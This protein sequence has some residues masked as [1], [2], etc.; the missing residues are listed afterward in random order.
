MSNRKAPCDIEEPPSFDSLEAVAKASNVDLSM[1]VGKAIGMEIVKNVGPDGLVRKCAITNRSVEV[2]PFKQLAVAANESAEHSWEYVQMVAKDLHNQP[3]PFWDKFDKILGHHIKKAARANNKAKEPI[4]GALS[5]L[6]S[7]PLLGSVIQT[8]NRS[9]FGGNGA[10]MTV[11]ITP[12]Q[13]ALAKIS[14]LNKKLD[15]LLIVNNLE[16]SANPSG[17]TCKGNQALMR[18]LSGIVI[19][20]KCVQVPRCLCLVCNCCMWLPN[21]CLIC[22]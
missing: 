10:S 16:P 15:C 9:D 22:I 8:A 20:I 3:D 19:C 13:E 18:T 2:L 6:L 21:Y 12:S 5:Q 7:S 1:S 11:D 4:L 17:A 14:S